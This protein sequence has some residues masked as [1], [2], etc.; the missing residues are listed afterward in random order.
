MPR[1]EP[2][3][4]RPR[5]D[6]AACAASRCSRASTPR[7]CSGSRRPPSSTSTRRARRSSARATS[8]TSLVVIVEGSVR[9]VH[10]EPDGTE[11]LIRR[12]GP[13][14][15][16][17]ELAV[18]REAPARRDGHRR[19][20]RRAR[21][22][23]R[24]RRPQGDPARATGRGDGDARDA[25]RA[26]QHAV[27]RPCDD[28]P[29]RDRAS[30]LPTGT[31]TF[32]RTDVEGSMGLARALGP[33]W[34]EVNAAHLG[35]P[36]RRR[37]ARTA[38]SC[39]RTE[40]D[41][42]FAAFPEAGAAVSAAVEAQRALDGPCLAGRTATVRVRMGL[43]TGRGPPRR[44]RLRRL[45]RQPRGAGRGRRARRPDRPVRRR[46][47]RSSSRR[48]PA[49]VA[50][51]R[52]RPARPQG[53][54][55]ARAPLPARRPGPADA[56]SRRCGSPERPIG[57]LPDR[58]TSFV[59]RD[60][61]PRRARRPARATP[62]GDADRARRHRQDEPRRRARPRAA[63]RRS[64]TAPGSS[65]STPSTDPARSAPTIARTLG[66]F[67][68]A[69]R[70]AAD[71]LAGVPRRAVAAAGPRQLRARARR[72][73]RRRRRSLRVSPGSRFVVT[74]RAP[75]HLGGE[76]EYPVRPLPSASGGRTAPRRRRRRGDAP[77]HRSRPGGPART[78]S[79]A[80]TRRSWPRS[81]RCS[82]G[83]RSASSSPPP[84]CRC[85]RRP[86]SATGSPR[87]CRCPASGRA[88][89]P[90]ASGR[91]RA[92]STGATTCCRPR[93]SDTLHALAVFEGGF[94]VDQAE[95]SSTPP[96]AARERCARP[97]HRARGAQPDRPRPDAD[98]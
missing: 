44:R 18:L 51:A 19:G 75:L 98:R 13:G 70:P 34:D 95:P 32:L 28:R 80:P 59:G 22:G 21:P 5:D 71:A 60:R 37:R 42:M 1:D 63:R 78:G 67:D 83:C 91:S 3:A 94:D 57:N 76:Q 79:Q 25:R 62:A 23:H 89:R 6:A 27:A 54:P 72:G 87:T 82:T 84:G 53:R 48:L 16:I 43:H 24:R 36:A 20:R 12:Y 69:D 11:R 40:G 35:D 73:R 33:A 86:P 58:L 50:R 96:T 65:R 68:G 31:V 52:P 41:A 93:S 90:P 26:D 61:R 9:V 47:A 45:R 97:A 74:S 46:R 8:A 39:V 77:V 30:D 55:G 56:T 14:D 17:G 10:A 29:R 4:R 81:A 88:T 2:D 64:P 49:G 92:R 66:L 85:C 38:A 15:H 7:T